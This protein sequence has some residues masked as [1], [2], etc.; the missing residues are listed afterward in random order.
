MIYTSKEQLTN[1]M[2]VQITS[3]DAQALKALQRIYQYQTAQEKRIGD[4]CEYNGVGFNGHD[5]KILSDMAAISIR[6]VVLSEK[7]M[8][9]IKA[10]IGKY[11][12]QLVNQSI[13]R[14]LIRKEG[15]TYVW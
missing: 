11:A 1:Q 7:Q 9:L 10:R 6:G 8:K 14:G 3:S 15:K 13:S 4:T 2:R 12:G 5:A